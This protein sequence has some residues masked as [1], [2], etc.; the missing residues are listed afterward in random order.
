MTT[1]K[2]SSSNSGLAERALIR[3]AAP[4]GMIGPALFGCPQRPQREIVTVRYQMIAI[5]PRNGPSLHCKKRSAGAPMQPML[6]LNN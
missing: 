2:T 6:R 5:T 1:L 3:R 4:A